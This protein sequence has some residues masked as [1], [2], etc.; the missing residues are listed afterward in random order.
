[1]TDAE[2]TTREQVAL[3]AQS[4]GLRPHTVEPLGQGVASVAWLIVATTARY[5]LRYMP[6][7]SVRQVTYLSEFA[8]LSRLHRAGCAVP[9]ALHSSFDDGAISVPGWKAWTLLREVPGRAVSESQITGQLVGDMASFLRTMHEIHVAG[10]GPLQQHRSSIE[11]SESDPLEGVLARWRSARVWPFDGTS[12]STST[13]SFA[14]PQLVPHLERHRRKMEQAIYAEPAVLLHSDLHGEHVF[15]SRERLSGVID[16]GGAFVGVPAWEFAAIAVFF[17]WES[18]T[19]IIRSYTTD[20]PALVRDTSLLSAVFAL[21]RFDVESAIP[22][23]EA[24]ARAL[25]GTLAAACHRCDAL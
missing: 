15:R 11:G 21:Y 2:S 25:V 13:L 14:A 20:R 16:F 23:H 7:E 3:V 6:A 18:A 8:I 22:R 4:C 10:Y 12:L 24:T 1:M 9:E 17:G 19:A 5:V